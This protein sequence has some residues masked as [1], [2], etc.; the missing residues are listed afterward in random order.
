[1]GYQRACLKD[2]NIVKVVR[3]KDC[4]QSKMT[5]AGRD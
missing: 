3:C 1:M 4:K 2:K 5:F